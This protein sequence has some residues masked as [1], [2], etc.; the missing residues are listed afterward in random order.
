MSIIKSNVYTPEQK[1][2]I[3]NTSISKIKDIFKVIEDKDTLEYVN[4]ALLQSN[5]KWLY[6]LFSLVIT[7][8]L[9]ACQNYLYKI[10]IINSFFKPAFVATV[11]FQLAIGYLFTKVIKKEKYNYAKFLILATIANFILF[12][13]FFYLAGVLTNQAFFYFV[14][15]VVALTLFPAIHSKY[16]VAISVINYSLFICVSL[17]YYDGSAFY[18]A[19]LNSFYIWLI[20]LFLSV[21]IFISK[22]NML[23]TSKQITN[24]A[25]EMESNND[26]LNYLND[27]LAK[28]S[29]TD[30][31]TSL[32][33]RRAYELEAEKLWCHALRSKTPLAVL[34]IDIDYFKQYNDYFGHQHG[35]LCLIDVSN[36]IKKCF[37]RKSDIVARYGGEEFVIVLA[38]VNV[39]QAKMMAQ[40]VMDSVID[41]K[42]EHP[43]SNVADTV[44]ISVGI[45]SIVP[46]KEITVSKILSYADQSLY[47][48]K[49]QGRNCYVACDDIEELEEN[50]N[51]ILVISNKEDLYKNIVL[52]NFISCFFIDYET[53]RVEF[54]ADSIHNIAI[55]S[56]YLDSIKEFYCCIYKDD[57]KIFNNMI[58]TIL[59]PDTAV[60]SAEFRLILK[61]SEI[62]W[63]RCK[64]ELL[65]RRENFS[66][67]VGSIL[68]IDEEVKNR[69][70]LNSVIDGYYDYNLESEFGFIKGKFV[71]EL[72]VCINKSKDDIDNLLN[73]MISDDKQVFYRY[74]NKIKSENVL[75]EPFMDFRFVD[76]NN[77]T[78]LVLT[79]NKIKYNE[80]G[81]ADYLHGSIINLKNLQQQKSIL[82]NDNHLNMVTGL[83]NK[84]A[85]NQ[86][87]A[88]L[89]NENKKGYLV[90]IDIDNF[91]NINNTF[92]F[93]DGNRFLRD[94]GKALM[95]NIVNDYEIYHYDSDSFLINFTNIDE[96]TLAN[97]LNIFKNLSLLPILINDI[98]YYYSLS[99]S[100]IE[101]P[102]FGKTVDELLVNG[103]IAVQKIKADGKNNLMI[104]SDDLYQE[105]LKNL[106]I[107]KELRKSIANDMEGFVLYYHPLLSAK[108]GTC[109][110][111]EA[112]LRWRNS[113]GIIVTP[114]ILI[115]LLERMN[116]MNKVGDWV[117]REASMQCKEWLVRGNIKDKTKRLFIS[118]DFD[119]SINVTAN[120]IIQE[121]FEERLLLHL[122][123]INLS[124]SHITL[125]LTESDLII[126][127]KK[128]VSILTSLRRHSIKIAIDDFGTGYSSLSYFRNL[129][130]DEIKIDRSFI[131]DLED[132]KFSREFVN[133]IIK[134]TQSIDR[135]ICV[136]GVETLNQA[137]ILKGLNANVLQ[138]FLYSKP[139]PNDVFESGFLKRSEQDL[140]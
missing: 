140:D 76:K 113:K 125:E 37:K 105:N 4:E 26:T 136:E 56:I 100:C 14:S 74:V 97:Q 16:I 69:D 12:Q 107:E 80:K 102:K 8:E 111:A 70:Y 106:S 62:V 68:S 117:L 81:K 98:D 44:T 91:S 1:Q 85:F 18:S 21:Y 35:D 86:H 134:I 65:K 28:L 23:I 43:R 72:K 15:A 128:A 120:Q 11:G 46:T 53:G 33:N 127:M 42:L 139:V 137:D 126:D 24:Y 83:K 92:S 3:E 96:E 32:G 25:N 17:Y 67:I 132:D 66:Y 122:Q 34:L 40:R 13:L 20:T 99:I 115:P 19:F 84:D 123:N 36:A 77:N 89:L 39:D 49:K 47:R 51:S 22:I 75:L 54:W 71:N 116:V 64:C 6:P 58:E 104:F 2:E 27:K 133:S 112:L 52:N 135:V 95:K 48:A 93:S 29:L 103:E 108:T 79:K 31:L 110:G 41:L 10:F 9:F 61:N 101:Y 124:P 78:S 59:T 73:S 30:P 90:I 57:I 38:S 119:I 109:I 121:S 131:N 5:V 50:N 7:L 129:P 138:G 45:C 82:S 60:Q 63:V 94:F 87:L 118:S 130:V 55:K 88:S 114:N